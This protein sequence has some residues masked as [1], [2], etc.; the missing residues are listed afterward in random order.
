MSKHVEV[1]RQNHRRRYSECWVGLVQALLRAVLKGSSRGLNLVRLLLL[2]TQ[3][4]G[5]SASSRAA[6][7]N[8]TH[9]SATNAIWTTTMQ[10]ASRADLSGPSAKLSKADDLTSGSAY[11][12]PRPG[13]ACRF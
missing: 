4:V 5:S 7:A 10:A 1:G 6:R 3:G 11:S 12:L 8:L 9:P 2:D 13:L